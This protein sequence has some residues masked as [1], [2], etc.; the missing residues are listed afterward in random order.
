MQKHLV[1]L[2]CA[3]LVGAVEISKASPLDSPDIVYID[4][5]P[6]NAACQAY[7]A[8]SGQIVPMPGQSPVI[9]SKAAAHQHPQ[10]GA[11]QRATRPHETGSRPAVDR[12]AK[13]VVLFERSQ[14]KIT[15]SPIGDKEAAADSASATIGFRFPPLA[16]PPI[17][18]RDRYL[19]RWPPLRQSRTE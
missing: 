6:C 16:P 12:T 2:T 7:M 14:A 1:L 17:L 11:A 8:W 13:K 18:L 15:D 19:S 10:K 3:S 9:A 5:Q 4:E